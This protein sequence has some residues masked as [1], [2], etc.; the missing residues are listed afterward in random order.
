MDF[1]KFYAIH[2]LSCIKPCYNKLTR[3]Y[4]VLT[5]TFADINV[6]LYLNIR[7]DK[8]YMNTEPYLA[9]DYLD[10]IVHSLNSYVP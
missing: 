3:K 5:F 10:I 2:T 9:T 7:E 4:A 8:F 1:G 6:I